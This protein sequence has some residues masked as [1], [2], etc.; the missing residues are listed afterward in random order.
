MI[1]LFVHLSDYFCTLLCSQK[2]RMAPFFCMWSLHNPPFLCSFRRGAKLEKLLKMHLSK[3]GFFSGIIFYEKLFFKKKVS[4]E[5]NNYCFLSVSFFLF[6][7]NLY[8]SVVVLW[9]LVAGFWRLRIVFTQV[10][11]GLVFSTICPISKHW[12]Q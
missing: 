12:V 5:I 2:Y 3:A 11:E 10:L 4:V 1:Y 8:L 9:F 6:K 7:R